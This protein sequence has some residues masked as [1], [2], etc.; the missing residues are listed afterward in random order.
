MAKKLFNTI[1]GRN[2]VGELKNIVQRPYLVVTMEDLWETFIEEFDED[3]I[4]HFVKTL[5]YDEIMAEV[6]KLP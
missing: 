6:E 3:C 4:V 2:L 5:E 1:Y